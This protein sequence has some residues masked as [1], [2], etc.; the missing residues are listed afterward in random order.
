[1]QHIAYC[2]HKFSFPLVNTLRPDQ[3]CTVD[4]QEIW[5]RHI[6]HERFVSEKT[7]QAREQSSLSY[8]AGQIE[9]QAYYYGNWNFPRFY[10]Y[11]SVVVLT[12]R[13]IDLDVSGSGHPVALMHG[14]FKQTQI[15]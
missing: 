14:K 11:T 3:D 1:M 8:L 10:S 5:T 2:A 15:F 13:S 12:G 6:F 9:S 4:V 7:L